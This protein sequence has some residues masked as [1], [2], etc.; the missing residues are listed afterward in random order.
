MN[1]WSCPSWS[2]NAVSVQAWFKSWIAVL[3]FIVHWKNF[4]SNFGSSLLLFSKICDLWK[5][6]KL[7]PR[8]YILNPK[9]KSKEL[10][11]PWKNI[12][13]KIIC[14]FSS[15]ISCSSSWNNEVHTCESYFW[16]RDQNACDLMFGQKIDA[17]DQAQEHTEIHETVRGLN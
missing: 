6:R 8:L 5:L 4:A 3:T 2:I 1:A 10:I 16:E 7:W 14:P 13:R 15:G 11:E 17:T 9:E 12:S